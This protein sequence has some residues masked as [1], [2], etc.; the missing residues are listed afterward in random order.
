MKPIKKS[1]KTLLEHPNKLRVYNDGY[2]IMKV[3]GTYKSHR[4][5]IPEHI[6]NLADVLRRMITFFKLDYHDCNNIIHKHFGEGVGKQNFYYHFLDPVYGAGFNPIKRTLEKYL[7]LQSVLYREEKE[8]AKLIE[9]TRISPFQKEVERFRKLNKA[10]QKKARERYKAK[11][12]KKHRW[13]TPIPKEELKSAPK[14]ELK[15]RKKVAK[16]INLHREFD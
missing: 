3:H 9:G 13:K 8:L 5:F 1:K 14:A 15:I 7:Y 10:R 11:K 6:Q 2:E 12:G 4:S 16:R